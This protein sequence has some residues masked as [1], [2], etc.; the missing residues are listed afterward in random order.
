MTMQDHTIVNVLGR[1]VWTAAGEPAFEA[2]IHLACG[3]RGRAIAAPVKPP[4]AELTRDVRSAP[5]ATVAAINGLVAA[6]LHGLDARRQEEIDSTLV[7][8]TIGGDARAR[9]AAMC[10]CSLATA[11][12]AARAAGVP[13]HRY[14]RYGQPA[15]MPLPVIDVFAGGNEAS[16]LRAISVLPFAADGVDH[17]LEVGIAIHRAALDACG[18]MAPGEYDEL[19][20]EALLAGIEAVG[21]IPGEE[22]GIVVDVAA[23]RLFADGRYAGPDWSFDT[24]A[25]GERIAGWVEQYPIAAV[26]EPFAEA[27]AT[28]QFTH[29]M[30]ERVRI[31]GDECLASDGERIAAAAADQSLSGAVLRPEAAGTLTELRAA[32]DAVRVARWPV[33]MGAGEIEIEDVSL[34]HV[35]TAWQSGYVKLGAVGHGASLARWN[36]ALRI[37]ASLRPAAPA[38]RVEAAARMVH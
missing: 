11:R 2:E 15:R 14:L 4:R 30:A 16:P 23:S 27:T 13:L 17:A 36:E 8:L 3:A 7:K 33:F 18:A 37:E 35:A 28:A 5:S 24:D 20:I 9:R 22:V 21:F 29:R 38:F 26:E 25:W 6:A 1:R 31:I 32:F 34:I 19:T 12:A 10:A